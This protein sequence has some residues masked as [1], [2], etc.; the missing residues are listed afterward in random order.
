[1]KAGMGTPV[2]SRGGIMGA[3]ST[4]RSIRIDAPVEWVLVSLPDPGKSV[5]AC[6]VGRNV[7]VSDIST[8]PDVAVMSC[9]LPTKPPQ[10]GRAPRSKPS[11]K[12]ISRH[13]NTCPRWRRWASTRAIGTGVDAVRANRRMTWQLGRCAHG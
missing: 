8:S 9:C 6:P 5:Q 2:F 1:M 7:S 13:A 12:L 4:T 10:C 11:M 3:I